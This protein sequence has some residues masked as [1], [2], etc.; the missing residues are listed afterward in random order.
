M[1]EA[2]DYMARLTAAAGE[3]DQADVA[4]DHALLD[5]EIDDLRPE[6]PL[7]DAVRDGR[8]FRRRSRATEQP[9][10]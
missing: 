4:Y 10:H 7:L 2:A 1:A 9:A 5:A 8:L 3:R 6:E